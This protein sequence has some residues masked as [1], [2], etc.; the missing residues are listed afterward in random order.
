M[1]KIFLIGTLVLLGVLAASVVVLRGASGDFEED[2][3]RVHLEIAIS[4]DFPVFAFDIEKIGERTGLEVGTEHIYQINISCPSQPGLILQSFPVT[5]FELL[6]EW[7]IDFVDID[8]DGFLDIEIL[9]YS[10]A[11][12]QTLDFYRWNALSG[13]GRYEEAPFF[14]LLSRGYRIFPEERQ[15]VSIIKDSAMLYRRE[16][17]QL[18]DSQNGEAPGYVLVSR[19]DAE[20]ER[21]EDGDVYTVRIY[22]EGELVYSRQ[23]TM[24]EYFEI[25]GERDKYLRY[26]RAEIIS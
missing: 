22:Y 5:S 21:G 6:S 9:Y 25:D 15:L 1:R 4:E 24:E 20:I 26:G 2:E 23:L 3:D 16:M 7:M 12:N 13:G 11:S 8:S 10:A 17:Y 19:E 18:A 14:G